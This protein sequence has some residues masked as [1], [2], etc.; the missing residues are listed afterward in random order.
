M[1]YT[2]CT[3]SCKHFSN[4]RRQVEV[5]ILRKKTSKHKEDLLSSCGNV[6]LKSMLC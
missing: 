5:N 6:S 1:E 2:E 4:F 3:A